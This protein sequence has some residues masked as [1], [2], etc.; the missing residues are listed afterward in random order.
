MPRGSSLS[1][2]ALLADVR[3]LILAARERVAQTVNV[4][5]TVLYWR[6]GDRIH[7][8]VLGARRAAY[9]AEILPTLSAKLVPEFGDGYGVR[10]LARMIAFAETFPDFDA[11]IQFSGQVGWSH[12]VEILALK[13]PL[14]RE[15]Y[16]TMSRAERWSVRTLRS[17]ITS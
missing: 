13:E 12:F 1:E 9:G 16:A 17:R 6:V 2:P 11:V 7:R 15:F 8:E 5:L 3:G 4:G 14:A 10:N